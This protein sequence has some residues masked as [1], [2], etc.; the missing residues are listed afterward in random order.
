MLVLSF[1]LSVVLAQTG[2][3]GWSSPPTQSIFAFSRLSFITGT[4]STA[5]LT[6]TTCLT[7]I[8]GTAPCSCSKAWTERSLPGT[9]FQWLPLNYVSPAEAKAI[10]RDVCR[11]NVYDRKEGNVQNY[12][13]EKYSNGYFCLRRSHFSPASGKFHLSQPSYR[14]YSAAQMKITFGLNEISHLYF[15][16]HPP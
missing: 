1:T 8:R 14:L 15:I 16:K 7:S 4:L 13:E 5:A 3:C 12:L 11:K 10:C 9:I 2:K 6:W